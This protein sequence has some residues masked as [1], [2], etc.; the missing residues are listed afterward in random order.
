MRC[1][2]GFQMACAADGDAHF[3]KL[4]VGPAC[5]SVEGCIVAPG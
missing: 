4:E 3:S 1:F 5:R 2:V